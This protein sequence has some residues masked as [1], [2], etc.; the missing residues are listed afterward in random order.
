MFKK[1]LFACILLTLLIS[2]SLFATDETDI[3]VKEI[4]MTSDGKLV[5]VVITVYQFDLIINSKGEMQQIE[6][7]TSLDRAN[8]FEYYPDQIKNVGKRGRHCQF[9]DD[10]LKNIDDI[11]VRYLPSNSKKVESIGDID[12]QYAI[13]SEKVDK[14]E[15]I[16]NMEIIYNNE[17]GTVKSIGNTLIIYQAGENRISRFEKRVSTEEWERDLILRIIKSVKN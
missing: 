9:E 3:R 14:I 2:N 4:R 1:N 17:S 13:R 16:E 15:K 12:L 5:G 10:R 11:S 6:M 7:E 8:E